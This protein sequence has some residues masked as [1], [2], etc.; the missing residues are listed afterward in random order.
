MPNIPLTTRP[1]KPATG[2]KMRR[3]SRVRGPDTPSVKPP[4]HTTFVPKLLSEVLPEP[5]RDLLPE[6]AQD[7][8]LQGYNYGLEEY[9]DHERAL[10]LGWASVSRH[11]HKV[12][13]HWV[14]ILAASHDPAELKPDAPDITERLRHLHNR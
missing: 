1:L 7:L 8:F 6:D 13:T 14:P 5:E 10:H 3:P 11:Y 9:G 2:R 4:R 12:G